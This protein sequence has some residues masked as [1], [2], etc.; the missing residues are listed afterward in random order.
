MVVTALRRGFAVAARA[1]L[2]RLANNLVAGAVVTALA[3]RT[4]LAFPATSAIGVALAYLATLAVTA[5]FTIAAAQVAI[6]ASATWT[7][8]LRQADSIVRGQF[9]KNR[10]LHTKR[11]DQCDASRDYCSYCISSCHD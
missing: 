3:V 10:G 8:T 1:A 5:A 9:A 6:T 7:R 11:R 2:G 4:A